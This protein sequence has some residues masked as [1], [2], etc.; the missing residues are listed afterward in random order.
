MHHIYTEQTPRAEQP[1]QNVLAASHL[2]TYNEISA[3]NFTLV[4]LVFRTR[5]PLLPT[6]IASLPTAQKHFDWT[7]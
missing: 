5:L 4:R 3:A 2:A 1:S 6:T 7:G